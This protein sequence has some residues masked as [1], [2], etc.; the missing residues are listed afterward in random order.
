VQWDDLRYFLGVAR[1]GSLT[2][3]AA[4][5][6]VSPSTVSRRIAALEADLGTRLFSHHQTG[7]FLT[8][9]G[10]DVLARAEAVEERALE[11]ER[12]AAGLDTSPSGVVRLA[13]AENLATRLIIPAL[14]KLVESY[15]GIRLEIV[16]GVD[17]VGLSRREADLALRL[18][19][20]DTGNLTRRRVGAMAHAV[21]GS[22]DYLARHPAPENDPFSGRALVTW[23]DAHAHL[24][25]ARWVAENAPAV[26]S[27]LAASSLAAQGSAVRAGLGLG[28][29]PCFLFHRQSQLVQVVPPSQVIVEDLW[30]IA[31][32]D[33]SASARIQ[34]VGEFLAETVRQSQAVLMGRAEED[35]LPTR[36]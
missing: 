21:Y 30:L 22:A 26:R 14:P 18:V 8:D 33:L 17:R 35:G 20:P 6:R 27:V 7:Y 25:A 10:R 28:V 19:R 1:T 3:T 31:H 13:T 29:L 15:P 5:L 11:L 16:T 4:D 12:G 9:Q 34:A 2:R 32:A 36:A 23:D 24:P